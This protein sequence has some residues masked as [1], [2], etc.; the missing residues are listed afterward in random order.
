M[1]TYSSIWLIAALLLSSINTAYSQQQDT[2]RPKVAVVLSGGGAKGF[3]H[4]GALK[5]LEQEN[6]PVDIVVGTSIGSIIGGLY[7][8]GYSPDTIEY[9][10]RKEDWGNL[11]SGKIPRRYLSPHD[12]YLEQRYMLSMPVFSKKLFT[13][14]QGAISSYNILNYFCGLGGNIPEQADFSNFPKSFACVATNLET[15]KKEVMTDG[16]LPSAIYASMAIPGVFEPCKRD[17]KMLVDGGLVDNFPYDVAKSMGADIIIGVDIR[18]SLQTKEQLQSLPNILNQLMSLYDP[19]QDSL[20]KAQCDILIRP[21]IIGYGASSFSTAAVDTLVRRGEEAAQEMLIQIRE[22]KEK[23]RLCDN[24]CDRNT[25]T[26]IMPEHWHITGVELEGDF[27]LDKSFI[28]KLLDLDLPGDYSYNEIK[29]AMDKLYGKESFDN[30]YFNLIDNEKGK[31][32]KLHISEKKVVSQNVGLKVNT[33]DA[34]AIMLNITRKDYEK[35]MGLLSLSAELSANPGISAFGEFY[36]K[37]S[38]LLGFKLQGKKQ[39]YSIYLDG[40][41]FSSADLYFASASVYLYRYFNYSYNI[42]LGINQDYYKGDIFVQDPNNTYI[43]EEKENF[44]LDAYAYISYDN[45][46]D[47]YFPRKGISAQASFSLI[48]DYVQNIKETT[49]ILSLQMRG[50]FP[51]N[52]RSALLTNIYLRYIMNTSYSQFKHTFAGGV[53]YSHYFSHHYPFIGMPPVTPLGRFSEIVLVGYRYQIM[54]K[55]YLSLLFNVLEHKD[56]FLELDQGKFIFGGGISYN[57]KTNMGPIDITVGYSNFMNKPTFS[58]NLG[59]WF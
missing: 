3:S 33:T 52:H 31:T 9:L 49:P 48:K 46:D 41:K 26:Y 16:F 10:C 13:L 45:L 30:I 54:K 8:I 24:A 23:H 4:I 36:H 44:V 43:T 5:V 47:Y 59:Y 2:L 39:Q 40:E 56:E 1:K 19:I 51:L 17:G 7:A 57:M 50:I 53:D 11:F 34:A 6:I 37:G 25:P 12:K 22:I 15:G 32:L 29:D 28:K 21:N 58:A 42:G 18:N 38:P 35:K 55:Q 14:P 20:N 27:H